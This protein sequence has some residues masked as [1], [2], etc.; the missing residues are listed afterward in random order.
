MGLG[1]WISSFRFLIRDRDAKFTGA[2]DEIFRQRRRDDS[3]DPAADPDR[4]RSAKGSSAPCAGRSS[5]GLLIINKHHLRQ[6][7]TEY[8][9]HYSTRPPAPFPRP[10]HTA[11]S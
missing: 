9:L 6:V 1:D 2:F 3:K 11:S 5:A 7:L 8:L 4:T 10:A